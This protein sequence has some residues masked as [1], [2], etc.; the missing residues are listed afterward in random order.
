MHVV[1]EL[2]LKGE[3]IVVRD[4]ELR[5]NWSAITIL[6]LTRCNISDLDGFPSFQQLEKLILQHNKI[7]KGLNALGKANLNS[8]VYLDISDNPLW[9]FCEIVSLEQLPRLHHFSCLNCPVMSTPFLRKMCF[10][11]LYNLQSLNGIDGVAET[12]SGSDDEPPIRNMTTNGSSKLMMPKKKVF[13]LYNDFSQCPIISTQPCFRKPE[14]PVPIETLKR[15]ISQMDN[16]TTTT[17]EYGP[18]EKKRKENGSQELNLDKEEDNSNTRVDQD[19]VMAVV[20]TEKPTLG[21]HVTH[22]TNLNP[23][24]SQNLMNH[25]VKSDQNPYLNLNNRSTSLPNNNRGFEQSANTDDDEDDESW[26][27]EESTDS[28]EEEGESGMDIDVQRRNRVNYARTG[29]NNVNRSNE[30]GNRQDSS[31]ETEDDS[32]SPSNSRAPHTQ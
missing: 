3:S 17:T 6:N 5:P 8:L 12:D 1:E 18:I 15:Q 31:E 16:D 19:P 27:H 13:K 32:F 30:K 2:D 26:A 22:H 9:N 24:L 7:E 21:E 4:L 28:Y 23:S 11:Y 14:A 10:G 20:A 25:F 29:Y